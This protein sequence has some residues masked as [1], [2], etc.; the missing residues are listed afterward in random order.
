MRIAVLGAGAMG[1]AAARL[2]A[3]HDDVELLVL[4]SDA[5]RAETV[6][7]DAAGASASTAEARSIDILSPRSHPLPVELRLGAAAV[8]P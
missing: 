1:S 6:A 5:A 3:R 2:L 8:A 4:D 7:A